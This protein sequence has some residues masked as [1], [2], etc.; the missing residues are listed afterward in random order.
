MKCSQIKRKLSAFM[1]GELDEA[2]SGFVGRHIAHCPGCQE[3]LGNLRSMDA[4]V[5][6]LPKV[7]PGPD[8]TPRVVS[9]AIGTSVA[10]G[11]EPFSFAAGMKLAVTRLFEAIFS[12]F[13]PGGDPSTGALDEFSD[14]PPLS[15]G[16]IYLK[17]VDQGSRGC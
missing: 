5:Y 10:G 11:D 9:A 13:E 14:C 16:F 7:E 15:M 2:T 4:L 6:G 3:H 12:L 17:L 1:D 8:F